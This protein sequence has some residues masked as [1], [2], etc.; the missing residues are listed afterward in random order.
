MRRKRTEVNFEL[1]KAKKDDHL[2]KRRNMSSL[3]EAEALLKENNQV[4]MLQTLGH[5]PPFL[6]KY[7]AFSLPESPHFGLQHRYTNWIIIRIFICEYTFHY[8]DLM[9]LT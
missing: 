6:F 8:F 7:E 3:E 1:R 9:D 2:S 5:Y 4:R